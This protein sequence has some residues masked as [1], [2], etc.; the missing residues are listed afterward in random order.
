M[1]SNK[2][3]IKNLEMA[4]NSSLTS[5]SLK[6]STKALAFVNLQAVVVLRSQYKSIESTPLVDI[7]RA[8]KAE[9][10][11]CNGKPN[12]KAHFSEVSDSEIIWSAL[13]GVP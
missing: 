12:D 3:G 13:L 6:A 2:L 11:A 5:P 10:D 9:L 1:L 8:V 7:R 4:K